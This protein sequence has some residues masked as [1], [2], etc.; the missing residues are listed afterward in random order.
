MTRTREEIDITPKTRRWALYRHE[1]A[2]GV[3]GEGVVAEG[4]Q[5]RDGRVAYRWTTDP[6]TTQTADSIDD[7]ETIHGH[8]GK[9]EIVWL[10]WTISRR[11]DGR[12]T[13]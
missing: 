7:V 1:D 5:F 6:R 4:V 10:D 8:A 11:V 13:A 3:S 12:Q 2:T 9:T